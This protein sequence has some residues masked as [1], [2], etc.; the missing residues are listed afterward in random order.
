MTALSADTPRVM[1][2][3]SHLALQKYPLAA[4]TTIYS[5]SAVCAAA[6]NGLAI[7]VADSITNPEFYGFAVESASTTLGDTHVT[8]MTK[9]VII[10]SAITGCDGPNDIGTTIYMSDDGTGFTTT[11]TD[12]VP[13]GKLQNYVGGEYRVAFE[14]DAHRSI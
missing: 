5:G 3:T 6:A 1:E 14:A 12:N 13:I 7:P 9:G 4:S 11:S 10:L 8:V 2:G